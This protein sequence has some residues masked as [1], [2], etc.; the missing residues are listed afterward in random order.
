M[1]GESLRPDWRVRRAQIIY[2]DEQI[3]AAFFQAEIARRTPRSTASWAYLNTSIPGRRNLAYGSA[4][5]PP[6]LE[7]ERA[8]RVR[9]SE[10]V[11]RPDSTDP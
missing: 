9:Y 2:S 3:A 6:R 8:S 4:G 7:A 1:D 5:S 11:E 10:C